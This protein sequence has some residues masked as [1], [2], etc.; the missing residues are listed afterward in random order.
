LGASKRIREIEI[1][2]PSGIRQ[3]LRD[4][5]ADQVLKVEERAN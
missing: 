1:S 5:P 2:W 4:V 3:V